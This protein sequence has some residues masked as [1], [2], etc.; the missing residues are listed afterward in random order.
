MK[1]NLFKTLALLLAVCMVLP[2]ACGTASAEGAVKD[3]LVIQGLSDPGSYAMFDAGS[4][5]RSQYQ[6]LFY[7]N[8][9]IELEPGVLTPVIAESYERVGDGVYHITIH[10]GIHDALG[11]PITVDDVV[12]CL[13]TSKDSGLRNS[14]F[15]NVKN[16]EKLDDRSFELAFEEEFVGEFKNLMCLNGQ[17]IISRASF[18]AS[19][20]NFASNPIGTGP[21][22][23]KSWNQGSSMV[24]EKNENYW[25]E[26]IK[27]SVQPYDEIEFRFISEPTQIAL[28][29]ETGEVDVAWGV[30]NQDVAK[31][32]EDKGF[33]Q[34][35]VVDPLCRMILFN[36]DPSNPFS[37]KRLRQAVCY[38]I[39]AEAT[40]TAVTE[41]IGRPCHFLIAAEDDSTFEDYNLAWN[42]EDYYSY[43]L[44][45]A[46]ELMAEAGYPDGGL[47]VRLMTKDTPEYNTT[48]QIFQAYLS[49]IGIDVEIMAYENALYQT[50]RYDPTAWDINLAQIGGSGYV[51]Q[52]WKWYVTPGAAGENRT[53]YMMDGDEFW[54]IFCEAA[55]MS[56]HSAETVEAAWDWMKE[57]VPM[58]AYG[59]NYKYV[60]YNDKV[61]TPTL[62]VGGWHYPWLDGQ[63][64]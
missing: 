60:I 8:L 11:N 54:P 17:V 38:A 2:L 23:I 64:A 6:V 41:G 45:K 12:W 58:Y 48:C 35:E 50:Y 26:E 39:D 46:K 40:I 28:A 33:H 19:T 31:F 62:G 9:F 43:N 7:E 63:N 47:K 18:E 51:V 15:A 52:P 16:I 14:V 59:Y 25:N 13:Q 57:E 61:Y 10:D 21:Y 29:L 44:E 42:D 49:M 4:S 27:D 56:T 36:C 3:R 34:I 20:D 37:D 32:T 53:I 24:L 22:K 55:H 30:A 5:V 1:K